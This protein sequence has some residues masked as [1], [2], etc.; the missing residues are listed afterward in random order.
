M[1]VKKINRIVAALIIIN[2][3]VLSVFFF[4]LEKQSNYLFTKD[5]V[6]NILGIV[7]SCIS[8]VI[9]AYFVILAVDAYGRI[10]AIKET[11]ERVKKIEDA[12]KKIEQNIIYKNRN[13]CEKSDK[14][15]KSVHHIGNNYKR[16]IEYLL[17]LINHFQKV[18]KEAKVTKNDSVFGRFFKK[19]IDKG[20]NKNRDKWATIQEELRRERSR[21]GLD[22]DLLEEDDRL[23]AIRDLSSSGTIIDV[24]SLERICNSETE[25]ENIKALSKEVLIVLREKLNNSHS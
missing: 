22:P 23:Q 15:E 14:A 11:E 2:I 16:S 1:N 19:K 13:I 25:S 24:E 4:C 8:I 9:T 10:E 12:V 5:D 18:E 17:M 7:V 3:I 20:T 6:T 21:I